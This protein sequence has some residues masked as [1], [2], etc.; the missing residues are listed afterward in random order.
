MT[1]GRKLEEEKKQREKLF[2]AKKKYEKLGRVG[3]NI[4]YTVNL[5]LVSIKYKNPYCKYII[6]SR[7]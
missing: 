1:K 5:V 4:W 2:L 3:R 6:V 7:K